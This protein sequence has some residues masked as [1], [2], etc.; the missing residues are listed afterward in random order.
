MGALPRDITEILLKTALNII[1]SSRM[2]ALHDACLISLRFDD[3]V[4]LLTGRN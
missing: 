1:Q 4:T 2:C 3:N